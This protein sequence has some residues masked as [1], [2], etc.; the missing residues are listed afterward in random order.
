MTIDFRNAIAIDVC[1]DCMRIKETDDAS[2]FDFHYA[3]PE[4]ASRLTSCKEGWAAL[5]AQ[6][7]VSNDTTDD[8]QRMCSDCGHVGHE[9]T[10]PPGRDD[11]GDVVPICP[12]CGSEDNTQRSPGRDEFSW[13]GCDCCGSGLGGSRT[14][15]ALFPR[16]VEPPPAGAPGPVVPEQ[17][18][19]PA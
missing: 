5:R 14:R 10:F 12:T 13:S 8:V 3:E 18:E 1:E 19:G 2:H 17:V 16:P 15:Y 6:G 7:V 9:N 11:D 4:S